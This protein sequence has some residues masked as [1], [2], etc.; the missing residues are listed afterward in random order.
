MS[1]ISFFLSLLHSFILSFCFLLFRS[2]KISVYLTFYLSVCVSV[3]LSVYLPFCPSISLS[4]CIY[5][6]LLICLT[7]C[8]PLCLFAC[9]PFFLSSLES[10]YFP[11]GPSASL[12]FV[13]PF[14]PLLSH[15]LRWSPFETNLHLSSVHVRCKVSATPLWKLC[16]PLN[17]QIL[18]LYQI[19]QSSSS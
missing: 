14:L 19:H 8:F 6:C 13:L 10:S 15:T 12:S 16:I 4:V 5:D 11:L 1:P 18:W 7:A 3:C 9:I 2:V 17:S